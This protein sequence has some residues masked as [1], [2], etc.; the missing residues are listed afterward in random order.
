MFG[1]L[2]KGNK[3][4]DKKDEI[5]LVNQ[6]FLAENIYIIRG[7]KFM[8]MKQKDLMNRSKITWRNLTMISGFNSQKRNGKI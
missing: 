1:D 7:Q 3:E 2:N 4:M 8:G 5:M 6:E